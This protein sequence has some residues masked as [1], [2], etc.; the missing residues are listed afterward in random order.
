M[1]HIINPS[2]DSFITNREGFSSKNFGIDEILQ[3]GTSTKSV[4]YFNSTKTYTYNG[5]VTQMTFCGFDGYIIGTITASSI[6]GNTHITGSSYLA[7]QSLFTGSIYGYISG[8]DSNIPIEGTYSITPALLNSFSGSISASNIDGQLSGSAQFVSI[9]NTTFSGSFIDFTGTVISANISGSYIVNEYNTMVIDKK[10]ID[11]SLLKFNIDSVSASIASNTIRNPQFYLKLTTCREIELPISYSVYAFPVS[12]SW[13]MGNGYLTDAGSSTGV[14][15]YYRDYAGGILWNNTSSAFPTVDYIN[16]PANAS[17]SFDMGGGTWYTSSTYKCSQV[18]NYQASDV[19]MNVTPI[20]M[21][22]ISGSIPNNGI[23]LLHSDEISTIPTYGSLR[24]FSKDTN[25]IYS[26][27]LQCKWDDSSYITA[28]VSSSLT[29]I[30]FEHPFNVIV[31]NMRNSYRAGDIVRIG[32]TPIE[33]YPMKN[34]N[35]GT[36]FD[37][38]LTPKALPPTTYYSVKDNESEEVF[39]DF[40]DYTKI[41]CG[42]SG[43]YFYLDTSGLPQERYLKIIIK[44]ENDMAKYTFDNNYIFKIT[45]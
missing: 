38:Y 8:S 13:V 12:Q 42:M 21:G 41:S 35:K 1:N 31:K 11:R 2:E 19:N 44:T 24:F 22:W 18:F 36:Q 17:A 39:V 14:S 5:T 4:K 27:T 28:S 37:A 34:F 16:Y 15:W 23:I 40:D 20:V 9:G 29:A 43:S 10:L 30:D 3:I 26:P 45:R 6:I 25:T 33:Q 32:V 7:T